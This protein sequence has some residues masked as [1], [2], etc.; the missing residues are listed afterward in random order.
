MNQTVRSILLLST[1]S[2]LFSAACSTSPTGPS[3]VANTGA[4]AAT[5][6]SAT[7]PS[8]S[9]ETGGSSGAVAVT[10]ATGQACT[11]SFVRGKVA[12]NFFLLTV[13]VPAG[14]EWFAVNRESTGNYWELTAPDYAL[15]NQQKYRTA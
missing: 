5:D 7:G 4:A 13:K 10:A 1:L 15:R 6:L 9:S 12:N 2:P 8:G 14:C 11:P 3:G